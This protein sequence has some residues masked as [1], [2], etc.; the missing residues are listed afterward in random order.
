MSGFA[1]AALL[2]TVEERNESGQTTLTQNS[3]VLPALAS[4]SSRKGRRI[5][6]TRNALPHSGD[7]PATFGSL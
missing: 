1:P 5:V 2:R 4:A 7:M 3:L 6:V